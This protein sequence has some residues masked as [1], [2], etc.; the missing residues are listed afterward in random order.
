[1][2]EE[3]RGAE[4]DCGQGGKQERSKPKSKSKEALERTQSQR[5]NVIKAAGSA[6]RRATLQLNAQSG[7]GQLSLF[8]VSMMATRGN[9]GQNLA[10][11]S[12]S[13]LMQ[14]TTQSELH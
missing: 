6:A 9:F 10:K 8:S 3:G 2:E 7:E 13:V 14:V 12:N 5:F 4:S 11:P 1:M